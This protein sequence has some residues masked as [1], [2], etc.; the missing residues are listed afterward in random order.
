MTNND[1]YDKILTED[2]NIEVYLSI[3]QVSWRKA[4]MKIILKFSKQFLKQNM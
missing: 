3:T 4:L 2:L 1:N